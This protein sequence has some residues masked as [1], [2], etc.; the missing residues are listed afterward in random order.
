MSDTRDY[1]RILDQEEVEQGS[2]PVILVVM[3]HT[4]NPH[5][6]VSKSQRQVNNQNVHLTVDCLFYEDK[7]LNCK[8]NDN[9]EDTLFKVFKLSVCQMILWHLRSLGTWCCITTK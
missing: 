4:I 7:L 5:Y 8:L 2:K 1:Q 3:H 9:L 6:V